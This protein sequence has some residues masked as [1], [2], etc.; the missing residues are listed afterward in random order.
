MHLS[1]EGYTELCADSQLLDLSTF[2]TIERYSSG[3]Q[4][5]Q[6]T[7][8][9][10]DSGNYRTSALSMLRL[11]GKVRAAG[12]PGGGDCFL[13]GSRTQLIEILF[14]IICLQLFCSLV[15]DTH[16][17]VYLSNFY[18]C[19]FFMRKEDNACIRP[20]IPALV[21]WLRDVLLSFIVK[22]EQLNET[23]LR[24]GSVSE[25]KNSSILLH[26]EGI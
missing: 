14:T 10:V 22:V 26:L 17:H 7:W 1:L 15:S 5:S 19:T 20:M 25:P 13:W 12:E 11:T 4:S 16:V 2:G 6:V 24:F 23:D 21:V 18:V 8:V 3:L 9:S